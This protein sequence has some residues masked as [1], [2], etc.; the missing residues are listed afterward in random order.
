M[1]VWVLSQYSEAYTT[2]MDFFAYHF[3]CKIGDSLL[4]WKAT[5]YFQLERPEKSFAH[6]SR[7]HFL[8]LLITR[9]HAGNS[10]GKKKNYFTLLVIR[11]ARKSLT[12]ST[13]TQADGRHIN[14]KIYVNIYV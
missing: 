12:E 6:W 4:T 8:H 9:N 3:E 11:K 13:V 14:D 5:G 7:T 2:I 10:Q 1:I